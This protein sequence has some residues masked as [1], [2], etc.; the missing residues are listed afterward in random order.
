MGSP[1]AEFITLDYKPVK[2]EGLVMQVWPR[3]ACVL[4]LGYLSLSRAFAYVGIP[5]WKVFISE[6]VLGLLFLWGPRVRGSRWLAVVLKLP[7]LKRLLAW[8][9]LFLGYGILQVL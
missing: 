3:V 8:Y 1:S 7:S 4:I 5:A 9:G 6:V 2:N